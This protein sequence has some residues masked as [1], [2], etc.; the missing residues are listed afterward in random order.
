MTHP[1]TIRKEFWELRLY[2]AG[3]SMKAVAAITNL[4]A[5]CDT[6]LAGRYDLEIIDIMENPDAAERDRVVALPTLVRRAPLPVRKIIGD[7]SDENRVI[8]A[9]DVFR[10]AT[11]V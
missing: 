1:Q 2:V 11:P 6:H 8:T 7:L 5:V 9:L 10:T 3:T 4:R